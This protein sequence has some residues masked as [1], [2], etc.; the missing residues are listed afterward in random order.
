[1]KRSF[2]V[3]DRVRLTGRFLR[4]TGQFTGPEGQSRWIVQACPCALCKSGDYPHLNRFKLSAT[5]LPS[6]ET[7][8]WFA[9][10]TRPSPAMMPRASVAAAEVAS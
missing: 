3:G 7:S 10:A 2:A 5:K 9:S 8:P 1:M 4:S 6:L